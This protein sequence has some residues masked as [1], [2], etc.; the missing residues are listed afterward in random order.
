MPTVDAD[1]QLGLEFYLNAGL[2]SPSENIDRL[3]P[4]I[5][6]KVPNCPLDIVRDAIRGAAAKF[7]R[8]STSWRKKL[9][10]IT[11]A[12]GIATYSLQLGYATELITIVDVSTPTG[13]LD[14]I[15]LA[16]LPR[17]LPSWQTAVGTPLWYVSLDHRSVTVY[18]TPANTAAGW[19]LLVE[20]ALAP[21]IF[22]DDL[23][24]ELVVRHGQAFIDGALADLWG[25]GDESWFRPKQVEGAA[26]AFARAIDIAKINIY[27]S[28]VSGDLRVRPRIFGRP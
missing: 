2:Y 27:H 18:P 5:L 10:A 3:L 19:T 17:F 22:A 26:G 20:A 14:P 11:V 8:D 16:E 1:L 25:M 24:A 23:E 7:F 9:P 4:S 28:R 13:W 12:D 6:P 21:E 15:T